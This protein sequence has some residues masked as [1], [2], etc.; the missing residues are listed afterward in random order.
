[1]GAIDGGGRAA[2]VSIRLP[3]AAAPPSAGLAASC[4]FAPLAGLALPPLAEVA[5]LAASSANAWAPESRLGRSR[6]PASAFTAR[7]PAMATPT[8]GRMRG[9]DFNDA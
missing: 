2:A 9:T 7:T 6:A 3:V 4:D 5:D 1:R 8:S